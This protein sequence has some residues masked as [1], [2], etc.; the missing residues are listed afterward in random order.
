[1]LT[2]FPLIANAQSSILLASLKTLTSK[3]NLYTLLVNLTLP[4]RIPSPTRSAAANIPTPRQ[5]QEPPPPPSVFAS[6]TTI[7]ALIDVLGQY[8]DV[9]LLV[10]RMPRRRG[11]AR[12]F[13]SESERKRGVEMVGVLEVVKDRWEGL[14]G[15]W[16]A[17]RESEQGIKEGL[18]G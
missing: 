18:E 2:A 9:D 10:G 12:L 14:S 7:P 15:A 17:F 11:D 6:N 5:R 4:H 8:T 3:Y 16:A 1:M 13:Y